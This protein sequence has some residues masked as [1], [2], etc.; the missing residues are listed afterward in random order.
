MLLQQLQ[1]NTCHALV[2]GRFVL[3]WFWGRGKE[4]AKGK[5]ELFVTWSLWFVRAL[6]T[7]CGVLNS[8]G[9]YLWSHT[10]ASPWVFEFWD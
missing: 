10:P 3:P 8:L 5:S 2:W 7:S 4:E 6:L 1:P 9:K